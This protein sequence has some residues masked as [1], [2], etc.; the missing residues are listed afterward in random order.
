MTRG[1]LLIL[2]PLRLEA[3][4]LSQGAPDAWV[5]RTG[6]GPLRSSCS[7][8]RIIAST[9]ALGSADSFF[10]TPSGKAGASKAGAAN[11]RASKAG[12]DG[13]HA[14]HA[15]AIA[16]IA[17][18]LDIDLPP[19]TLVVA[20]KVIDETGRVAALLPSA[21]LIAA[22]LNAR[23]QLA[24]T[25]TVASARAVVEGARDRATLAAL[26]AVAVDTE[27]AWLVAAP[28]GV[29]TAVVRVIVDT[30]E[31]E[32]RSLATVTGGIK[33]LAVLSRA[34]KVLVEWGDTI[35]AREVLLANPR[36]FCAG[37]ER[38]ID[39]VIR[40]IDKFGTPVYVRRHIV[41]NRHVVED[42][43]SRGAKFVQELD[44]IPDGATVI[45]SAHGV[46]P[47]VRQA[48]DARALNVVDATCPL[49]SKVHS[50]VRRFSARSRQVI[51]IGHAQHD[52]AEGTLGEA[53]DMLV[54]ETAGDVATLEVTDPDRL[55][56]VTQTTLSSDDVEAVLTELAARFPAIVGPGASD[57]C[58]ATQ[59]RQQAL[60]AIAPGCSTV[61]VIGS[62]ESSNANRLVEVAR[63]SAG[64]VVLVDDERDLRFEHL[65]DAPVIG[66]TA[67]ASTPETV[68]AR[69][70]DALSGVGPTELHEFFS[71]SENASFSLPLEV[72]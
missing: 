47:A 59:N 42:L 51:F 14:P 36:S 49:V 43:E 54:V 27:S 60:R 32:L 35:A 1:G 58:Y 50:E 17:G 37:V 28:W 44:E 15:V 11:G 71:T 52:E 64:K 5:V 22:E 67:A 70:L 45:F 23:G 56:Y 72:R 41:H 46:S 48:A 29:P 6:A 24:V 13:T 57:I 61:I 26:G 68:V 63:R 2:A 31:R 4:A 8:S 25:G 66:V 30:P 20:D 69:V 18:G 7:A 40:C 34:A 9:S 3:R 21:P 12:A 10:D 62:P 38:A 65:R 53:P 33:A 39:T 55:A 16:G 19:G